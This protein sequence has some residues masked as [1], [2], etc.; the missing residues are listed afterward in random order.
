MRGCAWSGSCSS[1]LSGFSIVCPW[2]VIKPAI[3]LDNNNHHQPALPDAQA[4][5]LFSQYRFFLLAAIA[6]LY[7][8]S[9]TQTILGQRDAT[10][11]EIAHLG[12][13]VAAL[14]FV[15]LQRIDRPSAMAR[16]YLQ[17]YLDI[18]FICLMM[19]ACGG[20]QSGFGILLVITIALFSQLNT[21]RYAL[22][23]AALACVLLMFEE[24]VAKL[25]LGPAAADFER[26]AFLGS[27]LLVVAWLLTVPLRKLGSRQIPE[28]TSDRA[29]LDVKQIANLN[30]EIIRELDSGVVVVDAQNYVQL[31]NDTARELLACEFAP[32]PIRIGRLSPSLLESLNFAK[33]GSTSSQP[34]TVE[35]TGLSLLPRYIGLSSGG[36]LVRLD[37]HALIRKQYQQLKL[38]SLGRLSA[39]IAH[40]IRNPLGAISH[41]VQL[42]QESDN[43][44]TQDAELLTIAHQHTGRINRIVEDILQLSNRKNVKNEAIDLGFVISDFCTRFIAE[45]QLNESQLKNTSEPNIIALFDPDHLD[46]VLWNL[47]T[48][49][50]LHNDHQDIQISITCWQSQQ[51]AAVIDI[52]DNGVGIS[53]LHR[54][55]L[56]EP[57]YSTHHNGSGLGLYIIRELCDLNKAHIECMQRSN[58]AHFCITLSTAERLAA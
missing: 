11:F 39:S 30:E 14:G 42:L 13:F 53:D 45:N 16:L 3:S 7:Y 31:I 24:L 41:A 4:M 18:I 32:L 15:Y 23:F 20:V 26:V 8:L 58:G 35:T 21:T 2:A 54:E 27:M 43:V 49:S 48:N 12:Y 19:Y 46:Q 44:S 22:F 10:L 52:I 28:P 47:C 9:T 55:Q 37:D 50:R 33:R 56:F 29:A 36:M 6:A 17:N 1:T 51:G 38:A 40:E 57:F 5:R 25:L 34:F